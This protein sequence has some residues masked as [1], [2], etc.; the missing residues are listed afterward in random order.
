M[1]SLRK[2]FSDIADSI[3]QKGVE[4]EI[5]PVEMAG[6]IDSLETRRFGG[7]F[8]H[9]VG[10]MNNGTL[11][12]DDTP[13]SIVFDGVETMGRYMLFSM[14]GVYDQMDGARTHVN[15]KSVS[16]PNLVTTG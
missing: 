13:L 11:T 8:D 16:F 9:W 12:Y 3:R 10:K 15:V 6:K 7:G 5:K 14:F 2:T 1:S 4:G